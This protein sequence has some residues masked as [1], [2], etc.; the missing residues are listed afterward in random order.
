[1]RQRLGHFP[2]WPGKRCA[3]STCQR[4]FRPAQ[5]K[6]IARYCSRQCAADCR[7]RS[8]RVAA[9]KKGGVASGIKRRGESLVTIRARV[10]AMSTVEAFLLGRKYGKA[11]MGNQR[12]SARRDGYSQGFEDGYD[13]A[14]KDF[15][16]R[17]RA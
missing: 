15:Q 3:N 17:R 5:R 4:V 11:D 9:G 8:A 16:I 6:R 12:Q 7:P 1:M 13:T 10:E 14:T 2:R